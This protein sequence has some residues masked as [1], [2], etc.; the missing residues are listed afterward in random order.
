M[1]AH[2]DKSTQK[3]QSIPDHLKE[4]G[5]LA[6]IIGIPLRIPHLAKLT[7]YFHDLGKWR[8][9]FESYLR[10]AVEN[11]QS[12][13]RGSVNHSSAG[14]VYI[15]RRFNKNGELE[16]TTVQVICTAILLP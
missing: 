7:A 2:I 10:A 1:I 3:E 12:A 9:R 6:W 16:K 5:E 11:P 4:T 13:V 8:I 14:A 15:H